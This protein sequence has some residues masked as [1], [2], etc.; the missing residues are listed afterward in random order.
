MSTREFSIV[1]VA[2][3]LAMIAF[4]AFASDGDF[5]TGEASF[6]GQ[7]LVAEK[8]MAICKRDGV[9]CEYVKETNRCDD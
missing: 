8:W 7:E 3:F 6:D 2:F 4:I 1:V 5:R 9:G